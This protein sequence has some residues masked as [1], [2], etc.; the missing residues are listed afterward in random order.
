[1]DKPNENHTN[2]QYFG[3]ILLLDKRPLPNTKAYDLKEEKQFAT[4]KQ[5]G[6]KEEAF[7]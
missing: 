1:M 5:K 3:I 7:F 4:F 6:E 2:E